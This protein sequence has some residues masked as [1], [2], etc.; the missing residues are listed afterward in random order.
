MNRGEAKKFMAELRSSKEEDMQVINER[1]DAETE[2]LIMD[3]KG[4]YSISIHDR[5]RRRWQK[6]Q[7]AEQQK[8]ARK[9]VR[10]QE[11]ESER[12]TEGSEVGNRA[13]DAEG[14]VAEAKVALVGDVVQGSTGKLAEQ[15]SRQQAQHQQASAQ[16][17]DAPAQKEARLPNARG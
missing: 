2:L 8:T 12:A 6:R 10:F 1:E 9:R 7:K 3:G 16:A 17:L 4:E 14:A 5:A 13:S 11:L 15:W